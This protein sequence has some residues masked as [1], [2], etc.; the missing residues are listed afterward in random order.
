MRKLK[1]QVLPERIVEAF[2]RAAPMTLPVLSIASARLFCDKALC[3][4]SRNATSRF[5]MTLAGWLGII[6]APPRAEPSGLPLASSSAPESME[7][8]QQAWRTMNSPTH[9]DGM[10]RDDACKTV[11][12]ANLGIPTCLRA[13]KSTRPKHGCSGPIQRVLTVDHGRA[14]CARCTGAASPTRRDCTSFIGRCTRP[15]FKRSVAGRRRASG[16][17]RGS[18]HRRSISG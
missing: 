4:R 14:D 10:Q 9:P 5:G 15:D 12:F 16:C 18:C 6:S 7:A 3:C 8:Q 2:L 1:R 17:I 13:S 11:I